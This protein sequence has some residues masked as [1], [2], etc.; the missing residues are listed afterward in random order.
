MIYRPENVIIIGIATYFFIYL[1]APL[2]PLVSLDLGSLAFISITILA[3]ALGSRAADRLRVTGER[4]QI[5][6]LALR[7]K[8]LKLFWVTFWLGLAGNLLRIVDK[9]FLRGVGELTGISAR[10]VLLEQGV[11]Q[12]S[13]LGGALYPFGYLPIFILLGSRAL[14]RTKWRAVLAACLFFIPA[15]DAIIFFSRSFLLLTVV[16]IYFGMSLT[17]FQGRVLPRKLLLPASIGVG[18]VIIASSMIFNLRLDEMSFDISRS[19]VHSGYAFTVVPNEAAWEMIN[20]RGIIGKTVLALLPLAQYYLHGLLEFQILSEQNDTQIFSYGAL[21]FAPYVKALSIFGLAS[22][23]DMFALFPRVG[24][25]T[26]FWGPL[27]VDFGWFSPLAMFIFGF[28]SRR[29]GLGAQKGDL[30][31]VPLYTYFCTVL[32]FMPV[33]NFAVASQGMYAI[34]AFVLFWFLTREVAR[35]RP[36]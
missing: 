17:L 15:L 18:T 32:F 21:L 9:Y 10:E 35:Y 4:R 7:R 22:D 28:I 5:P 36:A 16:M 19:I 31:A 1:I 25:F 14:P 3:F 34:N 26:S 29:L 13:L 2:E 11:G 12:A 30:G 24:V 23:P 27:W 8:E 6:T 33:V 20:Q